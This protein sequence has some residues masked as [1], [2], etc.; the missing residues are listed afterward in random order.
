[1]SFRRNSITVT[2]SLATPSQDEAGESLSEPLASGNADNGVVQPQLEVEED[3][4]DDE[5]TNEGSFSFS[6]NYFAESFRLRYP[7]TNGSADDAFAA[8]GETPAR[9]SYEYW[10][11]KDNS[12][13]R[14]SDDHWAKLAASYSETNDQQWGM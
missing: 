10:A 1:M 2:Y 3:S 9:H 4:L 13:E 5:T 12:S 11:S 8:E 14:F 6:Q 7:R